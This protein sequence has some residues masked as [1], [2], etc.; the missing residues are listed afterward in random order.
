MLAAR[1][2]SSCAL[3]GLTVQFA[4]PDEKWKC[5]TTCSKPFQNFKQVTAES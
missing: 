2:S 5:G 3:S 4:K 1:L